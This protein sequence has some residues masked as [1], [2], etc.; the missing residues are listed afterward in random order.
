MGREYHL[1]AGTPKLSNATIVI[2]TRVRASS[3]K[4]AE[5]MGA[6]CGVRVARYRPSLE[7]FK[8][9]DYLM[10]HCTVEAAERFLSG[11]EIGKS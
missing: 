7:N 2:S 10:H 4:E 1:P 6:V 5:W 11:P 9:T 3:P 8:A